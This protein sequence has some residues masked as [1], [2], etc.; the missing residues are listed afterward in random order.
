MKGELIDREETIRA[1]HDE[2]DECLNYDG[3]GTAI[4]NETERVLNGVPAVGD[5]KDDGWIPVSKRL[6][7]DDSNVLVTVHF[8]GIE[9]KHIKPYYYIEVAYQYEGEW[10]SFTDVV[11]GN[12]DLFE[13]IAWKYLPKP[14]KGQEETKE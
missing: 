10:Y 1:V 6:P 12:M 7:E 13:V 5:A 4:A 14:Y 11:K 3:S 9:S 2:W 8:K